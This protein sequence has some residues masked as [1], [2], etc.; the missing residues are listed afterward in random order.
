MKKSKAYQGG[1]RKCHFVQNSLSQVLQ[2]NVVADWLK[3][4]RG[5]VLSTCIAMMV[6]SGSC[7]L[8]DHQCDNLQNVT[9]PHVTFPMHSLCLS[10]HTFLHKIVCLTNIIAQHLHAL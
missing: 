2:T 5:L 6:I 10:K 8:K 3:V 4:L 9:A 1:R 7:L